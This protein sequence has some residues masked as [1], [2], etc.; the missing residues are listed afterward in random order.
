MAATK[1]KEEKQSKKRID[2]ETAAV[3]KMFQRFRRA[4]QGMGAKHSKWKMIDTFDR[5]EQWKNANLPPW[6]PKPV[7]NMIRYFRTLKRANLASAI[8]KSTFYPIMPDYTEQVRRLQDAYDHI[9]EAEKIPRV[10]RKC[11]DRAIAQGTGIAYVYNDETYIGGVY[12]E[13]D[14]PRNIMYQGRI[15]AKWWANTNFFIDPDAYRLKDAKFM[16]TTEVLPLDYIRKNKKFIEYAGKLKLQGMKGDQVDNEDSSDG[17]IFDRDNKPTD[18]GMGRTDGEDMATLHCH[19]ERYLNDEGRWQ[20]DCTYYT[21]NNHFILYKIEDV[22]PNCYPFAVI[23]YEEE[24]QDFWGTGLSEDVLDNQQVINKADQTASIIG[25]L[26]QNPQKVVSRESGINAQ[27]LAKF[28]SLPG[29]VWTTNTD[30]QNS[31]H[32]VEPP[33]IPKGLFELSDRVK[34]DMRETVGITES[35]TGES[36]GS[37]TTSTGVNSL[38]ERATVRDKDKMIQIDDFIEDLSDIIVKFVLYSWKD[39]R[40]IM[41]TNPN[42]TPAFG[43]YEPID[44]LDADNL[45]YRVKSDV[46]A[47]APVTQAMKKQ[48]ADQL[49]QL[50]GQFNFNPPIITPEEWIILQDFENKAD[51]LRRMEDDRKKL[52]AQEASNMAQMI[53][54]V[55]DQVAQAKAA[56]EPPQ[57]V[58]QIAMQAAQQLLQQKQA[59]DA[60]NGNLSLPANQTPAQAQGPKGTTGAMAMN[61]MA[62]GM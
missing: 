51:I 16:E 52:Q 38:I 62:K 40:P 32:H 26:H 59:E 48:Q 42:G 53:Q 27:E 44:E 56:G 35:Y 4:E 31:I 49:M 34:S 55:A 57:V 12:Y 1:T 47:R 46:Y 23:Y 14:D 28:G 8:P 41:K 45:E 10:V 5:G 29:R 17:T 39:K 3:Q 6:V 9:W 15:C 30:P 50:Q 58:E 25:V 2:E 20:L 24:E 36:V 21:R 33:D 11:V 43:V 61:A 54:Q 60:K 19:W 7:N 22:K 18:T 13:K 37:L